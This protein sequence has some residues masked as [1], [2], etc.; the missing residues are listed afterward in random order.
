[1]YRA[2]L[3]EREGKLLL[4]TVEVH[5]IESKGAQR[6]KANADYFRY[7]ESGEE[8]RCAPLS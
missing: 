4:R 5:E 6:L 7:A 2:A 3:I 8:N 1:M